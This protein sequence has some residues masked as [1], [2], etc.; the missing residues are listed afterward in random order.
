[1]E[2][3]NARPGQEKVGILLVYRLETEELALPSLP[4]LTVLNSL[5][6]SCGNLDVFCVRVAV[7]ING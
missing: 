6:N 1:M 3:C 4:T 7:I 2:I 5:T